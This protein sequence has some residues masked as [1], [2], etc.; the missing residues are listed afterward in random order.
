[1]L[2]SRDYD[3]SLENF[4]SKARGRA[5][6]LESLRTQAKRLALRSSCRIRSTR[7]WSNV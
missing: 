1:M 2:T 7:C 3:I 6:S 5:A 4:A